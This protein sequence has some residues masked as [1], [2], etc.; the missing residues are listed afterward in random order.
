LKSLLTFK[1]WIWFAVLA[2]VSLSLVVF[3]ENIHRLQ[4]CKK[5][6]VVIEGSNENRLITPPEIENLIAPNTMI[7]LVLKKLKKESVRINLSKTVRFIVI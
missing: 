7:E 2:G 3:A 6:N 4:K 1:K 5:I